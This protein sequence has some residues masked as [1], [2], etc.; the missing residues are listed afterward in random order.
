MQAGLRR[1]DGGRIPAFAGMTA[2]V[3][4]IIGDL[5]FYCHSHSAIMP[6]PYPATL[7]IAA[8]MRVEWRL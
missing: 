1:N 6:A 7:P 4:G 3:A 8:R 5:C 2:G